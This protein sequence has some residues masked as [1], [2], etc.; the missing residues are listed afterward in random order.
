MSGSTYEPKETPPFP[1]SSKF[2]FIAISQPLRRV[3][4]FVERVFNFEFFFG[5]ALTIE[6]LGQTD[7]LATILQS[8][9]LSAAQG[10]TAFEA[11]LKTL[12]SF[13]RSMA[14]KMKIFK[15]QGLL[16]FMRLI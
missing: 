14:L 7:E 11:T 9:D 1:P 2:G 6:I 4:Y 8:K 12:K 15:H 13:R 10:K 3:L 5:L 16:G